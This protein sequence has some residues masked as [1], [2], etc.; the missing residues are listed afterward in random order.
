MLMQED[1][2][3]MAMQKLFLRKWL[4]L[5]TIFLKFLVRCS[6]RKVCRFFNSARPE[7]MIWNN[8]LNV[9][10]S[11]TL[12][13]KKTAGHKITIVHVTNENLR[14]YLVI[15]NVSVLQV[16]ITTGISL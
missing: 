15:I 16:S 1:L 14:L 10:I 2:N 12:V 6:F 8:P 7:V 3:Q 4:P 13:F 5:S 11:I 9:N